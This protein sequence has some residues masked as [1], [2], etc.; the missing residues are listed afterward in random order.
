MHRY[1]IQLI[2]ALLLLAGCAGER[3]AFAADCD[4][5]RESGVSLGL[6]G[7]STAPGTIP[8]HCEPAFEEGLSEGLEQ[9]CRPQAGFDRALGGQE[10]LGPCETRE[11]RIEFQLGRQ[12]RLLRAERNALAEASAEALDPMRLRIV[13]RELSQIEGV[14]RIRSL[15]PA[16]AT[17]DQ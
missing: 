17:A 11:F 8:E 3:Q 10:D 13:E 7:Q 1:S 15:L 2:L 16:D 4:P 9:Y 6:E 12:I 5:V 14:A